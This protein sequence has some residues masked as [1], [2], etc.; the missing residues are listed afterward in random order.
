MAIELAT[1]FRPDAVLLDIG[2]PV[3]D[4]FEVARR[5]RGLAGLQEVLLVA[6]SGYDQPADQRRAR[7]VGFDQYLTKP[8]DLDALR[9]V[10]SVPPGSRRG[11][12]GA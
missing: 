3:I 4:G 8:I 9:R 10:L 7:D 2:L 12:A 11:H 5:L 6:V 1:R